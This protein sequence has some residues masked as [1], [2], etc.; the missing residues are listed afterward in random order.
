[1][2]S[3]RQADSAAVASHRSLLASRRERLNKRVL[4]PLQIVDLEVN[5]KVASLN[6]P[7]IDSAGWLLDSSSILA[8]I[9]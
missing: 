9:A 5:K 7:L 3:V 2:N 4:N 8:F 6:P 1:M